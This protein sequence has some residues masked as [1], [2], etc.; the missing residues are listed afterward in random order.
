MDDEPLYDE[1]QQRVVDAGP[2]E[3][4]FVIAGPGTGKTY[5][6]IGRIARLVLECGLAPGSVLVMS[7]TKSAVNVV[8]GELSKRGAALGDVEPRTFDSWGTWLLRRRGEL[9]DG[10]LDE[11]DYTERI[12]EA[13]G[14]VRRDPTVLSGVRHL[15]VDEVQDLVGVRAALV[16]AFIDALPEGC[17]VT[18]LGDPCQS[19]YDYQVARTRGMT[20]ERFR[21]AVMDRGDFTRLSLET[22]H[23]SGGSR[24]DWYSAALGTMRR[25]I[26]A[27]DLRATSVATA[28]AM[29]EMRERG[30]VLS[31]EEAAGLMGERG[32]S[33]VGVL[34][35]T[36]RDADRTYRRLRSEG[37]ECARVK[38]EPYSGGDGAAE[39]G[40]SVLTVHASKG[41]QFDTVLVTMEAVELFEGAMDLAG[42]EE[43]AEAKVAYVALTRS[44]GS[45]LVVS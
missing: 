19:L 35:R 8:R 2:D 34:T 18:L 37:V 24:P 44:K 1:D 11:L 9:S 5:T 10:E 25:W 13:T 3:R 32:Q 38:A 30:V 7:F 21:D 42:S 20:S 15:V 4:L 43:L 27:R 40:V 14:L 17:G 41:S 26:L 6:L 16:L 31:L 29:Y 12:E 28:R 33:K 23:R 45:T 36:N 39:A 22:E